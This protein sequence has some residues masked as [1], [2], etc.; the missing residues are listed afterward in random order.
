MLQKYP[1][2]I[3][4]QIVHHRFGFFVN[5]FFNALGN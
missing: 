4:I 2:Y 5:Q 1:A 3:V